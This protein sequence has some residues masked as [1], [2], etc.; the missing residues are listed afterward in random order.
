MRCGLSATYTGYLYDYLE[1][2][3][4]KVPAEIK[5]K[6][7]ARCNMTEKPTRDKVYKSLSSQS[8][9][10]I[11]MGALEIIVFA[12]MSRLLTPADFGYFAIITAVV[13]VFQCLTEAGLGSAV[14]QHSKAT[15]E[16]I[17]TALGLSAI[18]GAFFAILLISLASPLSD[19]M[20]H[21]D[22]LATSFR[23]MSVTL[24]LCS[25]NSVARAVFMRSLDFMKF[26]WCQIIAYV[27][28]SAIGIGMAMK[29]YGIDSVIASAVANAIFMTIIL[30]W[31]S[32]MRLNF[33]IYN[34]HVKEIVSYGGWLTGSVVVRRIT[35]E[36]DKFILTRLIPVSSIGAYNRPSGF[37]SRITDQVNGVYDTVLFPILSR[38]KDDSTKLQ[39]SFLKITSLISWFSA[40]LMFCFILGSQ[41]LIDVFFGADWCWLIDLFKV[42]S[43]S[44]LFLAYSRI[45]D[46]YFRSIGLV[47]PYFYVRVATC[48]LTLLCVYVGCRYDI[49]CVAIGVVVSRILDSVIK[50][51]YLAIKMSVKFSDIIRAILYPTWLTILVFTACYEATP[52]IPHGEY[53]SLFMF[54]IIG[55]FLLIFTPRL[56]GRIYYDNVYLVVK[57]KVCGY[58]QKI[59]NKAR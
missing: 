41:I 32:G 20:G 40:I 57:S 25:I 27:I 13:G 54:V 8:I 19:L 46:C 1:R 49:M 59:T 18:L 31:V 52:Y 39:E 42:L 56:F 3:N 23:L 29:G 50:Y 7:F 33:K 48:L 21:G 22:K 44:V 58:I 47:K 17:S 24:L 30:F 37:I 10:V 5:K 45:G 14:I 36:L 16:Y 43:V 12:M 6:T 53:F 28:S 2:K 9:V 26:G 34:H 55:V 38:V 51:V 15:K 11:V 4:E 35:T